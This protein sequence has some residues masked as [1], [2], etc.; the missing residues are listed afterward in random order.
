VAFLLHK[1]RY[2]YFN[3]R[4]PLAPKRIRNAGRLCLETEEKR[5]KKYPPGGGLNLFSWRKIEET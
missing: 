3:R 5:A 4:V 1:L 2:F